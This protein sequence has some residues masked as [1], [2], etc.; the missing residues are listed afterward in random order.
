M[1]KVLSWFLLLTWSIGCGIVIPLYLWNAKPAALTVWEMVLPSCCV[2]LSAVSVLAH[3]K[4][5]DP[6]PVILTKDEKHFVHRMNKQWQ[7]KQHRMPKGSRNERRFKKRMEKKWN[8]NFGRVKPGSIRDHNISKHY[9]RH[10]RS[11]GLYYAGRGPTVDEQELQVKVQVLTNRVNSL[12]RHIRKLK[13]PNKPD[14]VPRRPRSVPNNCVSCGPTIRHNF[15]DACAL[16]RSRDPNDFI[17]SGFTSLS[18]PRP[19]DVDMNWRQSSNRPGR[20]PKPRAR[21]NNQRNEGPVPCFGGNHRPTQAQTQALSRIV[22]HCNMGVVDHDTN[23]A[24][25]RMAFNAP[26]TFRKKPHKSAS[27]PVCWDSGCSIAVTFCEEDFVGEI[28]RPNMLVRLTGLAKGLKI[29]GKG[30]VRWSF[31]DDD[32]NIRHLLLDAYLVPEAT[33]RLIGTKSLLE[34]YPGETITM[35]G[36]CLMF[37]GIPSDPTKGPIKV[38][39]NPRNKLPIADAYKFD[40]NEAVDVF[41]A[42]VLSAD[43]VP[44]TNEELVSLAANVIQVANR[45]LSNVEKEIL[46][47][48][49]LT[50][51]MGMDRLQFLFRSGVLAKSE[52]TRSLHQ[53]CANVKQF[54]K[55][56]ACCY[57]KQTV[58]STP[59]T[60]TT[61]VRDRA[62]ITFQEAMRP[63][64]R[65][66]VDHMVCSTKGRLYGSKGKSL[67]R[68]MYCG[69]CV[70]YDACSQLIWVQG[71]T[72]LNS[73]QTLHAKEAFE[74]YSRDF[75]VVVQQYVSDNASAFTSAEFAQELADLKQVMVRAAPGAHHHNAGGER[76]IRTIT[77][78]ARTMMIHAAIHWPEMSDLTLWPMAVEHAA[79]LYNHIP[80]PRTGLAPID[81]FSKSRWEQKQLQDLHVWGCPAYALH[82]SL[83]DGKSIPRFQPRST[84]MV[85]M[86]ISNQ[87]ISRTPL[88]LNPNTG[89][90]TPKFNVVFD[91]WFATVSSDVG[92]MPD[93]NSP[94]WGAIFGDQNNQF[95]NYHGDDDDETTPATSVSNPICQE[96]EIAAAMDERVHRE[97]SNPSAPPSAAP[98]TEPTPTSS[99]PP[100]PP[101]SS[102]PT[103]LRGSKLLLRGSK[104]LLRGSLLSL[105]KPSLH[106]F[107]GSPRRFPVD[108]P[109]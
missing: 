84:R 99:P 80:N 53:Q 24:I 96:S 103:P 2:L 20:K 66:F 9:P 39:Y 1:I 95:D 11:S 12:A 94:E 48:H 106:Q 44:S 35:N 50:G 32:G 79:Y 71:Q 63:G 67:E 19:A 59:A 15:D 26:V 54:P 25:M 92:D 81:L 58:K 10:L 30:K 57:G 29:K 89:T 52:T 13:E 87:H 43:Q 98:T 93:M 105:L 62:G 77:S 49:F 4:A 69:A 76:A 104:L 70:F 75:G 38:P 42:N 68:D 100:N 23:P 88:L 6:K 55:C 60:I 28:V 61:K 97:S 8:S 18:S 5:P 31:E 40:V 27:F 56:A 33:M 17:H 78:I 74:D 7:S 107:R 85:N 16:P 82:K 90:I 101:S 109:L 41:Q 21:R 86:G 51:H 72:A 64:Q 45:N 3:R 34:Q 83:S 47:W 46:K 36:D 65:V 37:S 22:T 14:S 91:D 73:H 102:A 108:L